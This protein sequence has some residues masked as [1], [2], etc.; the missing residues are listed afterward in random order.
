[1]V[2]GRDDGND[3]T[4]TL[5]VNRPK[6][7]PEVVSSSIGFD[8]NVVVLDKCFDSFTS[9][10]VTN[11]W[12]NAW[13]GEILLSVDNRNS[14]FPLEC[15]SCTGTTTSTASIVVDGDEDGSGQANTRCLN[16]NVC[17]LVMPA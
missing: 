4:L 6:F 10:T 16:G 9:L 15:H 7:E 14:Y 1:V 8:K 3:G 11:E 17:H 5:K 12:S 2:T 13:K